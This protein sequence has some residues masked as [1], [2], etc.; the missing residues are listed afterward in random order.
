MRIP[1]IELPNSPEPERAILGMTLDPSIA[2]RAIS[3]LGDVPE[4]QPDSLHS[5]RENCP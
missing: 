5:K 3:E 2:D 4:S 1:D